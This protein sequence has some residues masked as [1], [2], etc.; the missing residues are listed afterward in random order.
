VV[1]SGTA[2]EVEVDGSVVLP[3]IVV[4]I[5]VDEVAPS[6]DVEVVVLVGAG[7]S[8]QRAYRPMPTTRTT[9]ASGPSQRSGRPR[10]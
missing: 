2:E 3:M 8:G 10:R 1:V 4:A 7:A 6:E 9:P 5:E